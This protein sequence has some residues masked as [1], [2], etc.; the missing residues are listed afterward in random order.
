MLIVEVIGGGRVSEQEG[1]CPIMYRESGQIRRERRVSR[2]M[3]RTPPS[4]NPL[5]RRY[6]AVKKMIAFAFVT[7][8]PFEKW[9][10]L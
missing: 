1:L 7:L 4:G 3:A 5:E 2:G 8:K 10:N 6:K 9:L